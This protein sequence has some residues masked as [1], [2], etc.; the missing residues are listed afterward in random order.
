MLLTKVTLTNVRRYADQQTI[1]FQSPNANKRVHLVSAYNG[2]GK[3]TLFNAIEACLFATEADPILKA[4]DFTRIE[5]RPSSNE[6]IVEVEFEH[7]SQAYV[8]NR[9][10]IRRPG[11]A[12]HLSNSVYVRSLLQNRDSGDSSTDDEEITEFINSL[13]PYQTKSLFL[14]DGEKVQTYTE[15][16]SDSVRDAIER[17]L[18]LHL[19]IRLQEDLRHVEQG[20]Q[21]ERISH[22]V[23]EDL[24]AK[25]ESVDSNEARL[26]SIERRRQEL[27]R[28][29]SE[30]KSDYGRLQLEETRLLGLFD[31]LTQAKRRELESQRDALNSDMERHENALAEL[32][33]KELVA[34]WFWPEISEAIGQS[35]NEQEG[36][37]TGISELTE[38]LYR[39]KDS[40]LDALQFESSDRLYD[41]LKNSLGEGSE[42]NVYFR[43]RSG[44][45]HLVA[46]VGHGGE[47]LTFHPEQL[48]VTRATFDRVTHEIG[49]LPSADSVDTNVK[50]L[51]EEMERL[52]TTQA[53]HEQSLR[54]LS[55][56][57]ERI[58]TESEDLKKQIAR[59]TEE[60]QRYRAISETIDM[61]REIRDVLEVF[62]NDYRSTLIGQLQ[63]IVNR[64]FQELT[65][66]PGLIDTVEIGRDSL[67]LKLL[68]NDSELLA[69]EQSAGQKEILAFAL[70][71]SVIELSNR[72]VP[73]IIDTP[74]ARLDIQ[75][76]NNVLR[77]FFPYLGPQV[78]VLATDTEVGREEVGQLSPILA[79]MHHLHLD[80]RTGCTTIRSG[81]L[82]E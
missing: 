42:D 17:L 27:R 63:D 79:T 4:R 59:L 26:R 67:E 41:V 51:H 6:M 31:P 33:P 77:R 82:D 47:R 44:L 37:P 66:S 20:L 56:E 45:D 28:S 5:S 30:A 16:G 54:A 24:L 15:D 12:E 50:S 48:Q 74:L 71:A 68:G 2:M 73:T 80:S 61:C 53:R 18:G 65:N 55:H 81:Y 69:E 76:R 43:I 62:V 22:D 13:I 34:C 36:L 52:L 38:F 70:I 8:L 58:E 19:Y 35:S 9:Q 21:Q 40:I 10:W 60:K 78:I 1:E 23:S 64:K 57:E 32:I 49:S 75:H 72:Q 46:L 7:E 14:F 25:Q 3:T 39:N 11:I 29:A